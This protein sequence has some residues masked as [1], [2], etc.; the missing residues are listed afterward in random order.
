MHRPLAVVFQGVVSPAEVCQVR[1]CR[2]S[3]EGSIDRMVNIAAVGG[4]W[5]PGNL[6]GSAEG[7]VESMTCPTVWL[8]FNLVR[9]ESIS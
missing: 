4:V 1:V 8:P 3:A 7:L 2:W 6:Q 9:I 5:Q